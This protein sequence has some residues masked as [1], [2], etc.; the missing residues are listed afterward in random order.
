M[1][2]FGDFSCY[3]QK[4]G[5]VGKER[6]GMLSGLNIIISREYANLNNQVIPVSLEKQLSNVAHLREK[7]IKIIETF[8]PKEQLQDS[9][10]Q[11]SQLVSFLRDHPVHNELILSN[12]IKNL[13]KESFLNPLFVD[14]FKR[15]GEFVT[16]TNA[17]FSA[18]TYLQII[19]I[20]DNVHPSL[21]KNSG[22]I[23]ID[24]V[25]GIVESKGPEA[26]FYLLVLENGGSLVRS[27]KTTADFHG[28]LLGLEGNFEEKL[29]LFGFFEKNNTQKYNDVLHALESHEGSIDYF[30]CN[31]LERKVL[32]VALKHEAFVVLDVT[33]LVWALKSNFDNSSSKTVEV[34]HNSLVKKVTDVYKGK[35]IIY[36][37]PLPFPR[38]LC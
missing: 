26:R 17:Q 9:I 10:G 37:F 21:I 7:D 33:Q 28:T 6:N 31:L 13:N 4:E 38:K 15:N 25:R 27:T 32:K 23:L 1:S 30:S 16:F 2:C 3:L 18:V 34:I 35:P 5:V 20:E 14:F 19:E 24:D 22:G 12:I 29:L 11:T 8:F 36:V